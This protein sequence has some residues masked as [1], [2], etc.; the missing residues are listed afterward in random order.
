MYPIN[1]KGADLVIFPQ[2]SEPTVGGISASSFHPG[3]ANFAF[4]DGSVRFIKDT[5][6][7]WNYTQ[8]QRDGNCLPVLPAGVT[9]GVYQALS[10]KA[11]GEVISSDQ[12]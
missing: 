9:A 4:A 5:I 6:N 1:L 7:T 3:G 12:Y 10:T 8:I 11:G 2:C